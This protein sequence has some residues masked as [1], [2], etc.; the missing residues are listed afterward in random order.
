M[1]ASFAFGHTKPCVSSK[2]GKGSRGSSDYVPP[3]LHSG[4]LCGHRCRTGP[5]VHEPGGQQWKQP[6]VFG[7][8][9]RHLRSCFHG[10][11]Q[12]CLL[13]GDWGR[14]SVD[15]LNNTN[16]HTCTVG[17]AGALQSRGSREGTAPPVLPALGPCALWLRGTG[18]HTVSAQ[19]QGRN[20]RAQVLW[21]VGR[22]LVSV[23]SKVFCLF[24]GILETTNIFVL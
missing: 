3:S 21:L 15:R 6:G 11:S 19:C 2:T 9:F 12:Y 7:C 20:W 5:A 14:Q 13:L 24:Q 16:I 10:I 1:K 18:C 17:A 23:S 22:P 4:V 8:G